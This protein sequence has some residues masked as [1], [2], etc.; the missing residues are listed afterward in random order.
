MPNPH[1]AADEPKSSLE[2]E[3]QLFLAAIE[4]PVGERGAWLAAECAEHPERRARIERLIA[5]YEKAPT[6]SEEETAREPAT[7]E[8]PDRTSP[9]R[10]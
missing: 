6:I 4:R 1:S 7:D 9:W 2:Q 5:E 10:L 3:K 8:P